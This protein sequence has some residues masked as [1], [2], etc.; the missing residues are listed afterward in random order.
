MAAVTFVHDEV[1]HGDDKQGLKQSFAVSLSRFGTS[2]KF[3]V[4]PTPQPW[5]VAQEP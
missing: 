3:T 1:F 5:S 4:T 2:I